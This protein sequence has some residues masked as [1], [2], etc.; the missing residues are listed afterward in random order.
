MKAISPD[1]GEKFV[2]QKISGSPDDFRPDLVVINCERSKAAIVD[3]TVLFEGEEVAFKK[4]R[5]KKLRKYYP[6]LQT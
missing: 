2:E 6:R 4:A 1:V 3:V 5:T